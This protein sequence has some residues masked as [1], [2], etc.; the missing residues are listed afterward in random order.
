MTKTPP[1]EIP[2]SKYVLKAPDHAV[3]TSE[4]NGTLS[5]MN[6]LLVVWERTGGGM[7]SHLHAWSKIVGSCVD[8]GTKPVQKWGKVYGSIVGTDSD[9]SSNQ[10]PENDLS[11]H[12]KGKELNEDHREE[13]G[14]QIAHTWMEWS[15][16]RV[17]NVLQPIIQ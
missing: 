6:D 17:N 12:Q 14:Q 16:Q 10:K 11:A 9:P 15:Q 3:Q 5:L 7:T 1:E 2:L 8:C 13:L 4:G